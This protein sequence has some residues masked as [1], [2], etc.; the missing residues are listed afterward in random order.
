MR[1]KL[2]QNQI[3][4][5]AKNSFWLKILTQIFDYEFGMQGPSLDQEF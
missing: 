5:F 1:G 4:I 3:F 2:C